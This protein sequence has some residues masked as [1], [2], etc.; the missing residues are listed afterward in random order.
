MVETA[1]KLPIKNEPKSSVKAAPATW[2]PFEDL[3]HEVDRLFEEFG[4]GSLLRPFRPVNLEPIFRQAGW[5]APA[6]DIVEKDKAFEITV[7]LP[8]LNAKDVEV[9][10]RNG[11]IVISGE[12]HEQKEEK[13]P[14][15][16][17]QER[18]YGSFE[19]SFAVPDGVDAGKVEA[20]FTN[21]ILLVTLPKTAE[22]QKPEKK[23]EIKAA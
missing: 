21:G 4:R 6:V 15:Y 9:T 2:R 20:S 12:K 23:V 14:D 22:A 3:R 17:L 18:R 13:A 16:Y 5:N 11:N 7:E 19:R 8:G 1:T 10:M